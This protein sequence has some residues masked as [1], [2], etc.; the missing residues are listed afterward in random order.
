MTRDMASALNWKYPEVEFSLRQDGESMRM[1]EWNSSVAEPTIEEM[2]D[3]FQEY[4]DYL[5][6]IE[7]KEKRSKEYPSV[8]DQLDV[9]WGAISITPGSNADK[10]KKE[11]DRIKYKHPKP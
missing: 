8:G 4:V 1:V 11:I 6:S 2:D 10:M 7:Y 9:L 5:D 3:I